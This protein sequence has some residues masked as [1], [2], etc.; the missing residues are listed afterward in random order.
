MDAMGFREKIY[1][2]SEGIMPKFMKAWYE[3]DL[4]S[5]SHADGGVLRECWTC[6]KTGN[7]L[8]RIVE[9]VGW[10]TGNDP[11]TI[12]E[13]IVNLPGFLTKRERWYTQRIRRKTLVA[14][15][16]CEGAD[17]LG[18]SWTLS[19]DVAEFFSG[20]MTGGKVVTARI[21]RPCAWLDTAEHE[22][23]ALYVDRRDI[24]SIEDPRERGWMDRE[25][26]ENRPVILPTQNIVIGN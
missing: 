21:Q 20:R 17:D 22:V 19:R 8:S 26:W 12:F 23:I 16:G 15:R 2:Q 9:N 10:N 1:A 5:I 7:L 13:Q 4:R 14:Y 25:F 24:L 6:S 11:E 3:N 18:F